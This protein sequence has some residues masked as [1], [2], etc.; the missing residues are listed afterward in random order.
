MEV[1]RLLKRLIPSGSQQLQV[2]ES[3]NEKITSIAANPL[4]NGILAPSKVMIRS[5]K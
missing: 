2:T 3:G 5:E 4:V 1:E